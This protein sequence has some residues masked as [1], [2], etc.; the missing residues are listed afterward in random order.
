MFYGIDHWSHC[1]QIII[2]NHIGREFISLR[3][4]FFFFFC[5]CFQ[6]ANRFYAFDYIRRHLT[7]LPT[8]LPTSVGIPLFLILYSSPTHKGYVPSGV[9]VLKLILPL[10]WLLQ[11]LANNNAA[12]NVGKCIH[13]FGYLFK[14]KQSS[15]KES[16]VPF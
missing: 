11:K 8:Y 1:L 14:E 4:V 2:Y 13:T 3:S 7:Y 9:N 6:L 10:F 12:A 5:C 16:I 15:I